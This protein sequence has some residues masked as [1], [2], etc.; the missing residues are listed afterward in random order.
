MLGWWLARLVDFAANLLTL[1][2]IVHVLLFYFMDPLHPVRRTVDR[3]VL[4][5]LRP[6][7]RWLPPVAGWDLS[8]IVLILLIEFLSRVLVGVLIRLPV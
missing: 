7:R 1:L 4:P 2:V 6:I 8:P 3:L 5:L